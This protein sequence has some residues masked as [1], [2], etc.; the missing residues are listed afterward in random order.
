MPLSF[1]TVNALV[2]LFEGKIMPEMS[3]HNNLTVLEK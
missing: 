2:V 3:I 1:D